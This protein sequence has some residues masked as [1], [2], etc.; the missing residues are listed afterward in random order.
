MSRYY[1]HWMY[2]PTEEQASSCMADLPGYRMVLSPPFKDEE[3]GFHREDWL[4]RAEQT[5]S[6][7]TAGSRWRDEAEEAAARHG[8]TYDGGETTFG[9]GGNIP[10][11]SLK[12]AQ[13]TPVRVLTGELEW[14]T[15]MPGSR[16]GGRT[17]SDEQLAHLAALRRA[18]SVSI[19]CYVMD[20]YFPTEEQAR[21]CVAELPRCHMSLEEPFEGAEEDPCDCGE[22]ELFHQEDWIVKTL[23]EIV[24]G[25]PEKDWPSRVKE[26]TVRH[27]G[28]VGTSDRSIKTLVAELSRVPKVDERS[29]REKAEDRARQYIDGHFADYLGDGGP[30]VPVFS[31]FM[32]S[33]MTDA[34]VAKLMIS[35]LAIMRAGR[36]ALMEAVNAMRALRAA[37]EEEDR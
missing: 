3:E 29:D 28:R 19:E 2:F 9:H 21:A 12:A 37:E 32:A 15:L 36:H 30:M 27:G 23:K 20:L 14:P 33:E 4:L 6:D 13:G 18:N 31:T 35:G 22:G 10:D 25:G 16:I 1:T 34:D 5:I 11:P 17:P 26:I 7:D 8:G 24:L